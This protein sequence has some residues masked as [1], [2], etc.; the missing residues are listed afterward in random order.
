MGT[1]VKAREEGTD[2]VAVMAGDAQMSP[3]DLA[4]VVGPVVAE[5]ADYVKG[6]RLLRD[7]VV[8]RMPRHRFIGNSLLTLPTKFATGYWHIID[9]QCGYTAISKRASAM[10]R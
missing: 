2:V 4:G 9:P 5:D 7:D 3:D 1:R 6:N 8:A 10:P